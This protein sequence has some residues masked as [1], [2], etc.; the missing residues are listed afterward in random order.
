MLHVFAVAAAH[1]CRAGPEEVP[2][3]PHIVSPLH[4]PPLQ[5]LLAQRA[6][7]RPVFDLQQ[8]G[9]REVQQ[10]R[11]WEAAHNA[12]SL[13]AKSAHAWMSTCGG[14]KSRESMHAMPAAC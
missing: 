13:M 3:Q 5:L 11:P 2:V 8:V 10:V 4:L 1:L 14:C 12:S 7:L 9:P 6:Y